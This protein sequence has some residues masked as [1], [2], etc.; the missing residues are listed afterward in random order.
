MLW[1]RHL[2]RSVP[3]TASAVGC[4][5]ADCTG[6]SPVT[7][8]CDGDALL[9]DEYDQGTSISV[10]FFRSPACDASWAKVTLDTT[11][12]SLYRQYVSL[13]YVPQLGGSETLLS[14]G[15]VSSDGYMQADNTSFPSQSGDLDVAYD[16][17]VFQPSAAP[18]DGIC[19]DGT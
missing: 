2:L 19:F 11:D 3:Q 9:L 1:R 10:K 16:A 14:G 17:V 8:G 5:G 6:L 13:F 7:E 12:G 4:D 15:S 18:V